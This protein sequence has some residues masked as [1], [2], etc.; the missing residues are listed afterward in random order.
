MYNYLNLWLKLAYV[1]FN[2]LLKLKS[3]KNQLL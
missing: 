3:I 1:H 2:F